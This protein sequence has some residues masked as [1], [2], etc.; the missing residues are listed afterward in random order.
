M[1]AQSFLPCV[2][3]TV[4]KNNKNKNKKRCVH[5]DACCLFTDSVKSACLSCERCVTLPAPQIRATSYRRVE[6]AL[7][8]ECTKTGSIR[9]M[10]QEKRE[11][12]RERGERERESELW[13]STWKISDVLGTGRTSTERS[14]GMNPEA[15]LFDRK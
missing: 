6:C 11:R 5:L 15:E 14:V 3:E 7:E 2:G 4:V 13:W 1:H 12:E 9:F 8:T 10:S